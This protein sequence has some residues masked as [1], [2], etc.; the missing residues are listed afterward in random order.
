[1]SLD[2]WIYVHACIHILYQINYVI[3]FMMHV[4]M[5][6][7]VIKHYTHT[8]ITYTYITIIIH[9]EIHGMYVT[10]YFQSFESKILTPCRY[11]YVHA[12]FYLH[13]EHLLVKCIK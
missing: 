1:M 9:V 2:A 5:Y 11:T 3:K 10:K 12:Y 13:I 8:Y 6:K 4:G 7:I